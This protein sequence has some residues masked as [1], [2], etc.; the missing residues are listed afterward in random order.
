M[1]PRVLLQSRVTVSNFGDR[2]HPSFNSSSNQ[3]NAPIVG[4]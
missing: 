3:V 2:F 4:K 1:S